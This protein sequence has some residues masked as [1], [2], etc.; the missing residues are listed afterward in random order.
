MEDLKEQVKTLTKI[1]TELTALKTRAESRVL[2]RTLFG[3]EDALS[4]SLN[5]ILPFEEIENSSKMPTRES[6]SQS[7]SVLNPMVAI[8]DFPVPPTFRPPLLPFLPPPMDCQN[9]APQNLQTRS[10]LSTVDQNVRVAQRAYDTYGP[11]DEQKR[12]TEALVSM[13]SSL[14]ATAMACVDVL[15]TDEELASSNTSGTGG[16]RQLDELKMSFLASSLRRK[17]ESP[18]FAS[19]WD[20]VRAR[21]NTKCRGNRRTAFRRLQKQAN[22]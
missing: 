2:N 20:D 12:K 10:P 7:K 16:Y 6:Q 11:T 9:K 19:Q 17:F 21:I 18:V 5:D 15:F 1:V 3:E 8:P 13:G 22:F 14:I 4:D